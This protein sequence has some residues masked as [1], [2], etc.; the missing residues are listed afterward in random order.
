[1]P[2]STGITQVLGFLDGVI[3]SFDSDT[4]ECYGTEANVTRTRH[5]CQL[6]FASVTGIYCEV[7]S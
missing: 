4:W 5:I 6:D 2:L 1:M 3:D 7:I